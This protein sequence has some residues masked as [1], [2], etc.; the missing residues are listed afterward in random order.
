[1]EL[2]PQQQIMDVIFTFPTKG[3]SFREIER[4]TSLSIATVAKH[5]RKLSLEGLVRIE[6][7]TNALYVK[8]EIG[9]RF[10]QLKRVS[11]LR[12]LYEIGLVRALE[13]AYMPDAII[14]FGSYSK[15]E[16]TEESD[17]DIAVI[18]R[19]S[20][21]FD[22][23]SFGNIVERDINIH[24]LPPGTRVFAAA[25]QNGIVLSG[26]YGIQPLHQTRKGVKKSAKQTLRRRARQ[27]R[28][29]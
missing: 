9:K 27:Q 11:N 4:K 6:E 19:K 8:G 10:R 15:G 13:R 5:V 18:S 1:M 25:L 7:R 21:E 14:L 3:V 12:Q 17:I 24:I 16:D 26:E 22:R 20:S 23:K 2:S 28:K 29:R